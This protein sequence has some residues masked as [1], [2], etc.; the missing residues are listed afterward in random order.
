M[1]W[2]SPQDYNEAL[3]NPKYC[4]ADPELAAGT[5]E[6]DQL[7]LPRP[8]SGMFACVYK[9]HAGA[10]DWAVRCF[11]QSKPGQVSRYAQIKSE[12]ERCSQKLSCL[13]QFN[14]EDNGI[15]V[16]GASFPL[17]KMEWCQGEQLNYWLAKNLRN[18]ALIE[19]FLESWRKTM[20]GLKECGIAH[21]DLQHGNILIDNNQIKLVDY[22]G[23]YIPAFKGLESAELG[24]RSYQHPGRTEKHFGP[25]LDNFSAWLIYLSVL[26]AACDRHIWQDF[27]GGDECLL[28]RRQDLENPYQSE[29]FHV[30][31]HHYNPQIRE[32]ARIIRYL[33]SLAPE[34]VPGLEKA[35]EVP[36][37]FPELNGIISDVPDWLSSADEGCQRAAEFRTVFQPT[38]PEGATIVKRHRKY[39]E[40]FVA[41]PADENVKGRWIYDSNGLKFI[42][43]KETT[44]VNTASSNQANSS[45]NKTPLHSPLLGSFTDGTKVAPYKNLQGQI[46]SHLFDEPKEVPQP[47]LILQPHF[48]NLVKGLICVVVFFFFVNFITTMMLPPTSQVNTVHQNVVPQQS[49]EAP[50]APAPEPPK[51]GDDFSWADGKYTKRVKAEAAFAKGDLKQSTDLYLLG[52]SELE[53]F[54]SDGQQRTANQSEK[55][56][57]NLALLYDGLAKVY[58]R[59]TQWP[60]AIESFKMSLQKWAAYSGTESQDYAN[61]LMSLGDAEIANGDL[62]GADIYYKQAVKTLKV[63]KDYGHTANTE[64][65]KSGFSKYIKALKKAKKFNQAVKMQRLVATVSK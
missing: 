14:F 15:R 10:R 19:E 3:Q 17:L 58:A 6:L 27:E 7:G 31:E 50:E 36:D 9:V 11:L 64:P 45:A 25:Y 26:I 13:V 28:F 29:L 54:Q 35:I 5:T 44:T 2:P 23:I 49:D 8:R 56:N 60:L 37:N 55:L 34:N 21:G 18:K 43:D 22:D 39:V 48:A 53:N 63:L 41:N 62:A 20:I 52:I 42:P 40:P 4:F 51:I 65:F 16:S 30:L 24:H 38:A 33:I 46:Y 59:Q 1:S 57:L 32:S 61:V 12:L 47:P